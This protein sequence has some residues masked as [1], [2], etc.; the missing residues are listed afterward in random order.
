MSTTVLSTFSVSY[1]MVALGSLA[2]LANLKQKRQY[3]YMVISGLDR[4]KFF[5]GAFGW[6]V[7]EQVVIQLFVCIICAI[8]KPIRAS[9]AINFVAVLFV[10]PAVIAYAGSYS[11]FSFGALKTAPT[12]ALFDMF[13]GFFIGYYATVLMAIFAQ[14]SSSKAALF[15]VLYGVLQFVSP[16]SGVSLFFQSLSTASTMNMNVEQLSLAQILTYSVPSQYP[17]WVNIIISV[18]SGVFY[19]FAGV[20]LDQT[21][22]SHTHP[23]T[24]KF[25][26]LNNNPQHEETPKLEIDH[27]SVVFQQQCQKN[28]K[29]VPPVVA[30]NDITLT[31]DKNNSL[32][33]LVAQNG[34]GKTTLFNCLLG[35]LRPQQGSLTLDGL[36]PY[37]SGPA[38]YRQMAVVL[39]ENIAF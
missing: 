36:T 12:V 23:T 29:P 26:G 35:V 6:M 5:A 33:G 2:V 9:G 14:F 19:F 24:N 1:F 16:G 32:I 13:V 22:K 38:Y 10:F 28:K 15:K 18:I 4:K 27:L 31:C 34:A 37:E 7:G 11:I 30:L 21:R 39:Q 3:T 20:Y 25:L 8:T 17:I